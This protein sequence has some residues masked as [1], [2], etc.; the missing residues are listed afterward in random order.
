MK[1]NYRVDLFRR[2][3][4][5]WE[6][7]VNI[8]E[9]ILFN[10]L[11]VGDSLGKEKDDFSFTIDN[12]NN[13]FI[14][15]LG[16][17]AEDKVKIY[18]W[19]GTQS[20]NTVSDFIM[21]GVIKSPSFDRSADA[22]H[23]GVKGVSWVNAIF[24][25]L[26]FVDELSTDCVS[27]SQT[28]ISEIN[29]FAKA[30]GDDMKIYGQDM[31]EWTDGNRIHVNP[32]N[33]RNGSFPSFSSV[34][35]KRNTAIELLDEFWGDSFTSDGAYM[36]WVEYNP[37]QDRHEFNVAPKAQ[38]TQGSF[39]SGTIETEWRVDKKIDGVVN[40][41]IF[42]FG[43]DAYAVGH[44][45]LYFDMNSIGKYGQQWRYVSKTNHIIPDLI[46]AEREANPSSF[47][48]DSAGNFVSNFPTSSSYPYVMH[49]NGVTASD[50]KEY[51]AEL[52]EYGRSQSFDYVRSYVGLRNESRYF[53]N[54][55]VPRDNTGSEL[56]V[57]NLYEITDETTGMTG[58]DKRK[59]RC[60]KKTYGAWK[61]D[62]ELEEDE[63]TSVL[64]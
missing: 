33:G 44:E 50:N 32:T 48:T 31:S 7:P 57:S 9:Y 27:L 63:E 20:V 60:V 5:F 39:T 3:G 37:S 18:Q 14:K 16:V 26:P 24:N 15:N 51:N 54:F 2:S 4:S 53:I 56:E 25:C 11:K 47:D 64:G 21:E 29:E 45:D 6:T 23:I 35:R 58:S 36:M 42:N 40:V 38:T 17:D 30:Q 41:C 12:A 1:L 8:S 34:V 52:V 61:I 62:Y 43:D 13:S 28:I 55:S 46:A 22:N 59:L 49:C 10:S 19:E